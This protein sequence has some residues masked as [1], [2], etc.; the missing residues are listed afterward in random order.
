MSRAGEKGA[1]DRLDTGLETET[2]DC[3]VCHSDNR[4]AAL[5]RSKGDGQEKTAPA[6]PQ[7]PR[8]LSRRT[9]FRRK[10]GSTQSDRKTTVIG[11]TLTLNNCIA[12]NERPNMVRIGGVGHYRHSGGSML[13]RIEPSYARAP[14][15]PK[16]GVCAAFLPAC[17]RGLSRGCPAEKHGIAPSPEAS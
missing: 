6:G 13:V 17:P 15:R 4:V 11:K 12:S 8:F 16:L 7:S 1:A 5:P 9:E 10:T 2:R 14:A 3:G